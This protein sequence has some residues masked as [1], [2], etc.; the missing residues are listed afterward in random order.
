LAGRVL[1]ATTKEPF[2]KASASYCGEGIN[3]V[4]DRTYLVHV[5]FFL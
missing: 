4:A 1:S 3:L 5:V 2:K